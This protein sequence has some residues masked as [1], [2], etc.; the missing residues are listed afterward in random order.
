MH[1]ISEQLTPDVERGKGGE[2]Q[3][4]LSSALRAVYVPRVE[5]TSGPMKSSPTINEQDN[6]TSSGATHKSQPVCKGGFRSVPTAEMRRYQHVRAE[7]LTTCYMVAPRVLSPIQ[8]TF[9]VSPQ[10]RRDLLTQ[11]PAYPSL[12]LGDVHLLLQILPYNLPFKCEAPLVL[13]VTIRI[14]TGILPLPGK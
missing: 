1:C 8:G 11:N 3:F 2:R 5:G 14:S 10:K 9:H 12:T 6:A 4:C 7:L 13:A